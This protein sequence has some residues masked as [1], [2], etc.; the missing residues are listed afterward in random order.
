MTPLRKQIIEDMPL[1][2]FSARTQECYAAAVGQLAKYYHR[3]P[4]QPTDEDLRQYFLYLAN[5]KIV[6]MH[7]QGRPRTR[8]HSGPRRT[9]SQLATTL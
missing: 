3:S 4:D 2:E 6:K 1:R 7:T 9:H 5:Q 8:N